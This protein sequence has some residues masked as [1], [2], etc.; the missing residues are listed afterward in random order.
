MILL[1]RPRLLWA[2]QECFG[3]AVAEVRLLRT[4]VMVTT[5]AERETMKIL[6][7]Y[8]RRIC[9]SFVARASIYRQ[10]E[11]FDRGGKRRCL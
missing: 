7:S 4:M 2:A 3:K 9:S 1:P 8:R 10:T 11:C 6:A 5:T